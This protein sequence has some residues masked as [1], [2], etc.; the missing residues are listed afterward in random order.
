[1][2]RY[3]VKDVAPSRPRIDCSDSPGEVILLPL[4][5][6]GPTRRTV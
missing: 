1:M 5:D 2:L 3:A 6:V 4:E